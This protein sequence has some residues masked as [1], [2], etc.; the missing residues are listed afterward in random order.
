M[1]SNY[2]RRRKIITGDV[3]TMKK[4]LSVVLIS[5]LILTVGCKIEVEVNDVTPAP[6]ESNPIVRVD[7]S[8]FIED[9]SDST[10]KQF[11]DATAE[12]EDFYHI[13]LNTKGGKASNTVTLINRIQYLQDVG[14]YITTEIYG[15]GMS[16]GSVLFLLGDTRIVH[17]GAILMFHACGVTSYGQ[18]YTSESDFPSES[19]DGLKDYMQMLDANF[20]ELLKEKTGMTDREIHDWMFFEDYNYMTAEEAFQLNIATELI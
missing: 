11:F 18:R 13:V 12:E 14:S 9:F 1:F 6:L 8:I 15:Y 10:V 5:M 2:L 16:A 4:L 19:P 20:A 7:G 17:S 3:N